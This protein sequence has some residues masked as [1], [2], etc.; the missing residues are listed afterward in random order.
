MRICAQRENVARAK[1]VHLTAGAAIAAAAAHAKAHRSRFTDAPRNAE[2]AVATATANALRQNAI[3]MIAR[4][5]Q[6]VGCAGN[7][8][9][10][11]VAAVT[12]RSA[13][14]GAHGTALRRNA[15]G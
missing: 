7:A 15:A 3:G 14:A 11:R 12:S 4:G 13:H 10:I 5:S 9:F 2:P 1:E 8:D 6:K